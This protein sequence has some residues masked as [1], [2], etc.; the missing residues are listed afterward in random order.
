MPDPGIEPWLAASAEELK[1][2]EAASPEP[3]LPAKAKARALPAHLAPP[4]RDPDAPVASFDVDLD[5]IN[6][7]FRQHDQFLQILD[8]QL[9]EKPRPDPE[10]A[11]KGS[12]KPKP[13]S[14][15]TTPHLSPKPSATLPSGSRAS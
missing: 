1:K 4:A 5:K 9:A 13:G 3:P 12:S 7:K 15:A 10:L 6:S 11:G 14:P 8:A 2:I